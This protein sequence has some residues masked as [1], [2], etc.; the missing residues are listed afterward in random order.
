MVAL[1]CRN[2]RSSS[3]P[4]LL[5]R[6]SSQLLVPRPRYHIPRLLR[7][8]LQQRVNLRPAGRQMLYLIL[9]KHR[10]Q[11]RTFRRRYYLLLALSTL[12]HHHLFDMQECILRQDQTPRKSRIQMTILHSLGIVCVGRITTTHVVSPSR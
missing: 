4:R 12:T 6:H 11:H 10:L 8:S 3:M 9:Q 1:R 5:H 2:T 7:R